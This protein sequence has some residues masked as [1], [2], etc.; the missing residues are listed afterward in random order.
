MTRL[1]GNAKQFNVDHFIQTIDFIFAILFKQSDSHL[2]DGY[3]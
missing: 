1:V 3:I 2:Q